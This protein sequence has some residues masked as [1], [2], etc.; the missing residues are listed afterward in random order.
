MKIEPKRLWVFWGGACLG[1]L[2]YGMFNDAT[3]ETVLEAPYWI[4]F[5]ILCI[6]FLGAGKAHE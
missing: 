1:S 5:T 4:A 3:L 2:A 6:Q